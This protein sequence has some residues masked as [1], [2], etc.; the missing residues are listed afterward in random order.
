MQADFIASDAVP[1]KEGKE[2]IHRTLKFKIAPTELT[3][4]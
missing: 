3:T 1:A 4:L 2:E